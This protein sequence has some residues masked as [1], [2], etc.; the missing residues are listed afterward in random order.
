[1]R[2]AIWSPNPD[3][4]IADP[5]IN[6]P[7]NSQNPLATKPENMTSMG[8][9]LVARKARKMNSAVVASGR[10]RIAKVAMLAAAT[11]KIF[12]DEFVDM[13]TVPRAIATISSVAAWGTDRLRKDMIIQNLS[14]FDAGQGSTSLLMAVCDTMR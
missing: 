3:D 7:T 4:A 1:M 11:A 8:A 6:P 2:A 10:L 9:S 12:T 13:T 14:R 5:M